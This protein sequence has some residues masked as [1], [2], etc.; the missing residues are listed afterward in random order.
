MLAPH[1]KKNVDKLWNR[2]WTAGITN[3]LVAVEQITYMLFLKRLEVIDD[4]RVRKG[5][6][7]I[8]DGKVSVGKQEVTAE[9]CRWSYIKQ[10]KTPQHL[11]DVVFPWLRDLEKHIA[12]AASPPNGIEAI[13]SRMSDA[14]FQ[15]DPNKG[16]ILQE[17]IKLIDELFERVDTVGDASDIMGDTF[18]YLLSEIATAGKNGQFRTPRHII[19]CMVELV[20]PQPGEKI[21]DPAAGTGGFLFSSLSY[22]LSKRTDP[23]QLRIEWD[24]TPHRVYGDQLTPE[25]DEA[26]HKGDY[27]VGF[28]NDRTMVRIG[29]MNMILHGIE[30]PEI[31]QR[32]SLGKRNENDP[33]QSESF[34]VVLANPPFTGTVD[35]A[36]LEPSI[37][38]KAGK[39]GKKA[40]QVITNKSELLFVWLMLDLLRVGG[41]CAV[42]VPEGVLFGNT[43]AHVKLR[44]ELLTEHLVE[45]IIS[46]PAGLFQPYA[47]VKTS[48]IVFQKETRREDKGSWKQGDAPRT[49]IV[50]FYEV[51]QEA[52]TLDAKRNERRGEDND[53]WDM[54]AKY[55]TRHTPEVDELDYYQPQYRTER[56]RLVDKHTLSVFSKNPQ[57]TSEKDQVRS[58]AELFAGLPAD[59]EAAYSKILKEQQ[60]VLNEMALTVMSR[61]AHEAAL[62]AK[63]KKLK[64]HRVKLAQDAMKRA[65]SSFRSLCEQ[66]KGLFDKE[67]KVALKL[68]QKAYRQALTAAEKKY[69]G[70]IVVGQPVHFKEFSKEKLT[71]PLENAARAFAQLDGYNVV[72]RSLEVFRHE[73]A[74]KEAKHWTAPVRVYAVHEDWMS[75][76]GKLKGS[77]DENGEVRPEYLTS[78]QLYDN[79]EKLI[80]NLL[81]PDCIEAR[82]WNLSAGQ[83]KP[84]NFDAIKSDKSVAEMIRELQ[85]QEK[86]IIDGLGKLL[87]MVEEG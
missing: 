9:Q 28:D 41:R 40:K 54:L 1:I 51:S 80:E 11:I 56:W 48:I 59:P 76:D 35:S 70:S 77:H 21:I 32:D 82:N 38:P 42:I 7:S 63:T 25:E 10:D 65:A 45:G 47:G 26:I 55:K 85:E 15:L 6:K 16:A 84:F 87:A 5:R 61:F 46:L 79:K 52:F 44:C 2:F 36:D 66:H 14:Y 4:E 57:V 60:P 27:L 3:P 43:A 58:I 78:I 62:K 19:R 18:E 31:H 12:R 86:K 72:L 24:G 13:G 64:K 30:N 73:E 39:T 23:E 81:D 75:E 69:Y 37:F 53:L 83:Y 17:A 33:L 68:Y 67:E 50:W 29:W 74:L 34:D 22:L 49:E 8:Y 20:D 71:E